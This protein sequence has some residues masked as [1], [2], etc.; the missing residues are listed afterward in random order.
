[1]DTPISA[2]SIAPQQSEDVP[3]ERQRNAGAQS[4]LADI[5]EG[6]CS[7]QLR[8]LGFQQPQQR[9]RFVRR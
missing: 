7:S 6:Y 2:A 9:L 8:K 5:C 4:L 1:M 3:A